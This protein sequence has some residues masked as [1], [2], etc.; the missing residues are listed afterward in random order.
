MFLVLPLPSGNSDPNEALRLYFEECE[1]YSNADV[2]LACKQFRSGTVKGVNPGWA[3]TTGQ[4]ATQLRE[5]LNYRASA[6]QS[7]N[8]LLG[9]FR[10]QELDEEW[11][12]RRTPEAKAYVKSVLDAIKTKE[13]TKTPEEIA[14]AKEDAKRHDAFY[15]N[16]F[17]ERIPGIK[18]SSYLID[19]LRY[20]TFNIADTDGMNAGEDR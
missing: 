2:D 9:Q 16:E 8:L 12:A 19:K 15:A 3:P 18:V 20:E 7:Q 14:R 13:R 6:I 11:Q 4:F 5:N 17:E 1:G 10:E